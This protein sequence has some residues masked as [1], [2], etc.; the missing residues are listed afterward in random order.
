MI[1][2]KRLRNN[3]KKKRSGMGM[4]NIFSYQPENL[5][6]REKGEDVGVIYME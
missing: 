3:R 1:G 4:N 2:L 6:M 5:K